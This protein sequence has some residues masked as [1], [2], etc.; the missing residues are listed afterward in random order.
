LDDCDFFFGMLV[1]AEV[2]EV[3]A[4]WAE[5]FRTTAGKHIRVTKTNHVKA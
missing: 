4:G 3:L 5:D 2:E 1:D